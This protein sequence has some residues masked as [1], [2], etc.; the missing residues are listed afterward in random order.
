MIH[1]FVKEKSELMMREEIKQFP[2]V[3]QDDTPNIMR[4]GYY[5]RKL[6]TKYGRIE[7]LWMPRDQNQDFQTQLF[8]P[9]QRQTGWPE[10]EIIKMYQ[11]L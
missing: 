9:H 4:N 7:G 1:E 5:Q 8:A 2:T 10:E 6:D 3:E 11:N